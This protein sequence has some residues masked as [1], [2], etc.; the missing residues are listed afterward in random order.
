MVLR[1]RSR[2]KGIESLRSAQPLYH[3][4]FEQGSSAAFNDLL[5]TS[6]KDKAVF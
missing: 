4:A 1:S 6:V 3:A 5:F 2:E